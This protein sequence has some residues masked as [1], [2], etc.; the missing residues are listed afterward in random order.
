MSIHIED[1]LIGLGFD[2]DSDEAKKFLALQKKIEKSNTDAEKG[3]Q[4]SD[5]SAQQ[6]SKNSKNRVTQSKQELNSVAELQKSLKQIENVWGNVRSGNVFGAFA[7]GMAGAKAFKSILDEIRAFTFKGVMPGESQVEPKE[8]AKNETAEFEKDVRRTKFVNQQVS[9]DVNVTS[10]KQSSN[11]AEQASPANGPQQ[12]QSTT[13]NNENVDDSKKSVL[14]LSDAVVLASKNM[15]GLKKITTSLFGAG[16]DAAGAGLGAEATEAAGAGL[17]AEATEAAGGIAAIGTASAVAAGGLA[18]LLAASIAVAGLSISIANG[19]STANTNVESMAA[20]M[21]ITDGAA[22]QL[23]NT[24]SSMG[25]TTADLS[26]IALNPTLNKQFQALQQYQKTTLQLPAD[27]QTVNEQWADSIQLPMEEIK[28]TNQYMGEMAGYDFEKALVGPLSDVL[29]VVEDLQSGIMSLG[30]D[31]TNF[32]NAIGN[33]QAWKDFISAIKWLSTVSGSN[34]L[35]TN[36]D[37]KLGITPS[38]STSIAS[39]YATATSPNQVYTVPDYTAAAPNSPSNSSTSNSSVNYTNA[40]QITVNANSS[41]PQT[42][43]Q[44]TAAAVQQSNNTAA[45][46]KSIQGV[47]R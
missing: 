18:G 2:L 3:A 13:V 45:L 17:G 29:K 21:W 7:S 38:A 46:I 19:V 4:K 20:Q 37:K 28:L 34:A 31:W 41:D 36:I 40:P 14:G 6:R 5:G 15:G 47:S 35:F 24:L 42:I 43:A 30:T 10:S 16:T 23:N 32:A 9:E 39:S 44:S 1:Y 8:S 33:S 27:F 25:K 22:W 26:T 12:A 11:P